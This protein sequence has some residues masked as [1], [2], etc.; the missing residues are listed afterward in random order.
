MKFG[1]VSVSRAQGC[2]AAHAIRLP[3][4]VLRKGAR[5]TAADV[6]ALEQG[7][8][9]EVVVAEMAADDVAEDAAAQRV[10]AAL[11][12]PGL[13]ADPAF[14]GRANI[15]ADRAGLLL[16]DRAGVDALNDIDEAV[17]LATL[18]EHALVPQ[19][20]MAAT[21]KIIPFAAPEDLVARAEALARARGPLVRLAPF[22]VRRV[23]AI[24][25]LLPGLEPKVVEK[26][27][28][29]LQRRL[30]AAG[31]KLV[32]ERRVPHDERSLVRSLRELALERPE[33]I[34]VFGAS[35]ITDRRDVIPAALEAA[36]GEIRRLGMPV[37][38]GN[39]LLLGDL[40]GVPVLGAPG[41]ARSPRENGFDWVLN[42]LLAKLPLSGRDISRMGVGGL[43]MEIPARP[44]PRQERDL[45]RAPS[46]AAVVLAAGRSTRMGGPNKL[47]E[48]VQGRPLVRH[49]VE[50]ALAAGLGEVLV[51]TGHQRAA[52]EAALS[53]L[54]VRFVPNPSFAE[55]LSTS[56]RAGL[57]ALPAKADGALVLLGDMPLVKPALLARLVA[58]FDPAGG[59]HVVAPVRDGRRGNPVLWGRRFFPALC[60]IEG[61]AGGR[62]LL[63]EQTETA[64]EVEADDGALIDVDTP[65]ALA[66]IRALG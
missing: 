44:Q 11:L 22:E 42:R 60:A 17:T 52:V 27:M 1:P 65:E 24:S 56:L 50:A 58:A 4:Y 23:A 40:A 51:V 3:G 18:D 30:A 19:G 32:A 7:G 57:E 39:L 21:V 12:G 55:G 45:P 46:V 38:P 66:A 26:T 33:I 9:R 28:T 15:F 25:T 14:T 36:G 48:T 63:A 53:G 29:V 37:D 5:I 49:A 59:A 64:R 61:D 16:V 20:A 13:R 62:H 8:V 41:C 2:V 10:A 54:P 34:I 6:T 35:A 43:L 31:A 47:L